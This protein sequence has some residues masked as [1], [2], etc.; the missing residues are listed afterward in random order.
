MKLSNVIFPVLIAALLGMLLGW[1]EWKI[2]SV[3]SMKV[4]ASVMMGVEVFALVAIAMGW[5]N[6]TRGSQVIRATA[7]FVCTLLVVINLLLG[8]LWPN[9][10]AMI[11]INGLLMVF[12]LASAF[13]VHSSG[14]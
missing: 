1:V 12:F 11:L 5:N 8:W 14:Q 13:K 9:D 4:L 7:S 2:T 6:G 3:E 10:T